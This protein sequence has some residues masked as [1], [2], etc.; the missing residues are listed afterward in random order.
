M[1]LRRESRRVGWPEG[2]RCVNVG[3]AVGDAGGRVVGVGFGG[4]DV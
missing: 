4:G 1:D 2:C 3:V